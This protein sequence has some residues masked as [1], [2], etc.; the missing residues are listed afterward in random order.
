MRWLAATR[1]RPPFVSVSF[2]AV[3]EEGGTCFS[4]DP[5]GAIVIQSPGIGELLIR[6]SS[7][8]TH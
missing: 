6:W 3:Y 7:V 1:P 5:A 8:W 4:F 2:T